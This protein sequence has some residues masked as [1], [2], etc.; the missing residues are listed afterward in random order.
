MITDIIQH[1]LNNLNKNLMFH[2]WQLL[3]YKCRPRCGGKNQRSLQLFQNVCGQTEVNTI[4][5]RPIINIPTTDNTDN[6]D[7]DHDPWLA[8][9]LHIHD[10]T[11]GNDEVNKPDAATDDNEIL[12]ILMR[13]RF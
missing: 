4:D 8:P 11:G 5:I 7:V 13:L 9:A 10:T 2:E 3:A 12:F 1:S 6:I